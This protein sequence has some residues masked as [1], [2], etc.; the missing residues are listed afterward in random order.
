MMYQPHRQEINTP[1]N[2]WRQVL[3]KL[4]TEDSTVAADAVCDT[5]VTLV[6]SRRVIDIL[7]LRDALGGFS[8]PP[9]P[10]RIESS[11]SLSHTIIHWTL[12]STQPYT[13]AT[14]SLVQSVEISFPAL[15]QNV[16]R[17]DCCLLYVR[18]S[19]H[20]SATSRRIYAK[21]NTREF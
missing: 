3:G 18:M 5:G 2:K 11:A 8:E 9:P 12:L 7:G 10:S 13:V 4:H 16:T 14:M 1:S 20:N 21:F 6:G 19:V 17:T 15:L